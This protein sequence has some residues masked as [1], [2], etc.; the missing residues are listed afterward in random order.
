MRSSGASRPTWRCPDGVAASA[1]RRVRGAAPAESRILLDRRRIYIVPSRAGLA[2]AVTLL[3]MLAGSIN[4]N[5]GLGYVLTFLLAGLGLVGMLHT[6]RNLAGLAFASGRTAPAFV[7]EHVIWRVVADNPSG[8]SRHRVT[9]AFER[10]P[11]IVVDVPA[12]TGDTADAAEPAKVR[13]KL[14]PGRL[15]IESRWPLGLFRAWAWANLDLATLVYPRPE[16][17][18]PPLPPAHPQPGHSGRH[19][20]GEDDF[21][22][23]R[24]YRPGDAPGRIAWKTAAHGEALMTKQFEGGDGGSLLWLDRS[25]LPRELDEERALSRLT[26]WVLAADTARLRYGLRLG[27]AEIPPDTGAAHRTRCLEVLALH[28]RQDQPRGRH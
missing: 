13:G 25:T 7:G 17:G 27:A 14:R 6:W 21:A 8:L 16:A 11:A 12:R 1:S 23:L 4:Y 24:G 26:A 15:R 3:L 9:L 10:A 5:L 22:G 18:A 2:L 19:A 20:R 28:G